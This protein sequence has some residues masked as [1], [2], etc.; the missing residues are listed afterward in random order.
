MHA[1]SHV[2]CSRQTGLPGRPVHTPWPLHGTTL[3]HVPSVTVYVP[4]HAMAGRWVQGRMVQGPARKPHGT[5][6]P[7]WHGS[8]APQHPEITTRFLHCTQAVGAPPIMALC[9][10]CFLRGSAASSSPDGARARPCPACQSWTSAVRGHTHTGRHGPRAL[11]ECQ[12]SCPRGCT[13]WQAP[14]L[15]RTATRRTKQRSRPRRA[16]HRRWRPSQTG[17][18]WGLCDTHT[19]TDAQSVKLRHV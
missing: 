11:T 18:G 4:G 13:R 9:S 1:T 17:R 5:T 19:C 8:H 16:P 3:D 14:P 6:V 7:R 2:S 10:T 12:G 15:R